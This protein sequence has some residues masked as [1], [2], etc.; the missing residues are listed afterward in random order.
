MESMTDY[1]TLAARYA[2]PF[3][4]VGRGE[5]AREVGRHLPFAAQQ[6][7]RESG[8]GRV[9]VPE[10][11]GGEGGGGAS[12]SPSSGSGRARPPRSP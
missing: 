2:A 3:D 9:G 4:A 7:L 12:S 8:F 11:F 10:E 5:R 1:A 6:A